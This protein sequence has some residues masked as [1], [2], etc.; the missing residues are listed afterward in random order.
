MGVS[1]RLRKLKSTIHVTAVQPKPNTAI[2]GL[3]NLET[4]YVS[5]IWKR[6][7]VDEIHDV[8][9]KEAEEAARLLA[10]EEGV[11]VGLSSG[12]IFHVA[13]RKAEEVEEGGIMVV[14]APDGGERYLS[15]TLCDP[16]HCVEAVR[17]FGIQCSYKDG[18]PITK[19]V[20]TDSEDLSTQ[21]KDEI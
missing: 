20:I 4:Q 14:I 6:E 5:P 9:P 19:Q 21:Q 2:Q 7:L 13:R 12:A 8:S 18:K 1:Q 16:V 3:K 17:K 11:F 10:L 15:A